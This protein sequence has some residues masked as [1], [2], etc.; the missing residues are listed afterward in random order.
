MQP[1]PG[2]CCCRRDP[3]LSGQEAVGVVNGGGDLDNLKKEILTEMRRELQCVKTEI[4][5]GEQQ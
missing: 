5:E 4:I 3:S 1:T 2:A